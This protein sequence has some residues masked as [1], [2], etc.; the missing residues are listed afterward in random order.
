MAFKVII[1]Q[2][3]RA[4]RAW[5]MMQKWLPWTDIYQLF[6]PSLDL[7]C[8]SR[9]PKTIV[10]CCYTVVE[11]DSLKR[12]WSDRGIGNGIS[13]TVIQIFRAAEVVIRSNNDHLLGSTITHART[14]QHNSNQLKFIT[15]DVC[16]P[17]CKASKW[18]IILFSGKIALK[19]CLLLSGFMTRRTGFPTCQSGTSA[20]APTVSSLQ[21]QK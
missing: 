5:L 9:K 12:R 14:T 19:S 20:D 3:R 7:S 2:K 1:N 10:I 6:E 18:S 16:S 11:R 8:T 13:I 21:T 4:S 15:C 17:R